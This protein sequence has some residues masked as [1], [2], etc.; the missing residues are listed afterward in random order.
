MLLVHNDFDEEV[1]VCSMD[2]LRGLN[3]EIMDDR[4]KFHSPQE[5]PEG[6]CVAC[7]YHAMTADDWAEIGPDAEYLWP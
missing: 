3:H 4:E 6:F 1:I 7:E 5:V 2:C